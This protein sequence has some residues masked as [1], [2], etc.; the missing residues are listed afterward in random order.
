MVQCQVRG[1][2]AVACAIAGR[3]G[4][5]WVQI[6]SCGGSPDFQESCPDEILH[7][8]RCP[9]TEVSGNTYTVYFASGA[10]FRT[11]VSGWSMNLY[12]IVTSTPVREYWL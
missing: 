11:Q 9:R 1:N 3:E 8:E 6:N 12:V 10:W 7:P 4:R 2:P 5:N